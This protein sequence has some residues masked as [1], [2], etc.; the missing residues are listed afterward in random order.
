MLIH[1]YLVLWESLRYVLGRKIRYRAIVLDSS[2]VSNGRWIDVVILTNLPG[3]IELST[4]SYL[5]EVAMGF[6]K[7]CRA[8]E[9]RRERKANH[10]DGETSV[11]VQCCGVEN[12]VESVQGQEDRFMGQLPI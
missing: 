7:V 4:N 5:L 10:A 3:R 8:E 2:G 9:Q 11:L 1:R 12:R 6:Y